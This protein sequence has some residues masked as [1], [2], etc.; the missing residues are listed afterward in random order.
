MIG[1]KQFSNN[2]HAN[3]FNMNTI[4][5]A[6]RARMA[7][8]F[9]EKEIERYKML[10]QKN[11]QKVYR[12]KFNKDIRKDDFVGRLSMN[13]LQKLNSVWKKD[14]Y[15]MVMEEDSQMNEYMKKTQLLIEENETEVADLVWGLEDTNNTWDNQI[16]AIN[17]KL[18]QKAVEHG[19]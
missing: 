19:I 9:R 10:M 16:D 6:K 7:K 4:Y 15:K 13:Q 11:F 5:D 2:F 1:P 3:R 8:T 17:L 12:D 18:Y 14:Y